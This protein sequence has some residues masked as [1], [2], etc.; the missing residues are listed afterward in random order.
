MAGGGS[1]PRNAWPE[2]GVTQLR[3]RGTAGAME[4][5][6]SPCTQ[7]CP[8]G[9]PKTQGGSGGSHGAD[10]VLRDA[11]GWETLS[12]APHETAG[13][14]A[15]RGPPCLGGRCL[16]PKFL[17][18]W[19]MCVLSLPPFQAAK[20]AAPQGTERSCLFRVHGAVSM[21]AASGAGCS[22]E[23]QQVTPKPAAAVTGFLPRP[24]APGWL[25]QT[26]TGEGVREGGKRRE[27]E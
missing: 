21:A 4:C 18:R 13:C 23:P 15:K 6:G 22:P 20:A 8:V 5:G 25:C 12:R 17:Y 27:T 2:P 3:A 16:I 11:Q 19:E 1:A 24:E 26:C 14:L 10:T 7:S 9:Y